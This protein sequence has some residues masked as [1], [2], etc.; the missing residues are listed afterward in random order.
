VAGAGQNGVVS[1][2]LARAAT[3]LSEGVPSGGGFLVQTDF[4]TALLKSVYDK[5]PVAN[6]CWRMEISGNVRQHETCRF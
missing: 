5:A 2:K 4:S 1:G 6:L 3:G